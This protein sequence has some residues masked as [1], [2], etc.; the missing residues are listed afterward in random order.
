M[1]IEC[2]AGQGSTRP[3]AAE[4]ELCSKLHGVPAE[5]PAG[6]FNP[7]PETLRNVRH[8]ENGKRAQAPKL[9]RRTIVAPP[10]IA[11]TSS[12]EPTR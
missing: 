1:P 4:A 6:R 8:P 12:A 9:R 3:S 10:N 11:K 5:V 7:L 2:D